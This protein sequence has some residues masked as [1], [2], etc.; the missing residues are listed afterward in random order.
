MAVEQICEWERLTG[1]RCDRLGSQPTPVE[2]GGVLR[3]VALCDEH[4]VQA[5]A[6]SRP[7]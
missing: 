5:L 7:A 4:F 3:W 1:S 6:R 2:E